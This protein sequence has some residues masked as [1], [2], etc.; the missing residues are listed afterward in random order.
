[1]PKTR[2]LIV[3][4]SAFARNRLKAIFEQAGHDV[5]GSASN[6]TQ[7]LN[8]FGSLKPD[9]VTLDYLMVGESG[10]EVLRDIIQ[11]DPSARVIM[12]SGSGDNTIEK[13]VL[14]AGAKLFISKFNGKQSF[15][16]AV[17]QVMGA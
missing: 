3:D 6:G 2:I 11:Q 15:I 13:R 10:E 8:L 14:V 16:K 5:V 4:D 17:D 7:A 1:M 12:V 9:V